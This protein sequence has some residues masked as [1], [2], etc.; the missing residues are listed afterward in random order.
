MAKK[1]GGSAT[2]DTNRA[3]TDRRN[4]EDEYSNGVL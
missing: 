2:I 3:C 1:A 4:R